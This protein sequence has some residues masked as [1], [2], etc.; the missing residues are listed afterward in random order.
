MRIPF[1]LPVDDEIQPRP[2]YASQVRLVEKLEPDAPGRI[3]YQ[4]LYDRDSALPAFE[5]ADRSD[6]AACEYPLVLAQAG[7]GTVLRPV[8]VPEGQMTEEVTHGPDALFRE[9]A[10]T[11]RADTFDILYLGVESE[12]PPRLVVTQTGHGR[13][14]VAYVGAQD[15]CNAPA[16][17]KED[18]GQAHPGRLHP[19]EPILY[20]QLMSHYRLWL[21]LLLLPMMGTVAACGGRGVTR[22][23]AEKL[24]VS[25]PSGILDDEDV[26]VLSV[27]QVSSST[28]I[29]ETSLRAAFR[30]EKVQGD[31]VVRE[32]R[33]GNHQW[34]SVDNLMAA[35]NRIKTEKARQILDTVSAALAKYR[36]KNGHLPAF[37]DYVDLSDELYPNFMTEAYRLDP[38]RQPLKAVREGPDTIKLVSSGPDEKMDTADDIV[39]VK[40]YAP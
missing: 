20:I 10:G 36:Q 18:M 28:A 24:L 7:D 21:F 11:P 30:M 31:W 33:L 32:V 1:D 37:D 13:P 2:E 16:S 6:A 40:N 8:F 25:L 3:T 39:L 38:W 27:S 17:A 29:A 4:E 14:I 26:K 12:R 23:S 35:L 9:L 5:A 19:L 22:S 15:C 34:E